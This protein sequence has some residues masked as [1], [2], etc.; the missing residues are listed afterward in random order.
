MIWS[1]KEKRRFPR[2]NA[3]IGVDILKIDNKKLPY[4]FD[5]EIGRNI[6]LGGICIELSKK[7]PVSTE[8]W[9][10]LLI[11]KNL[12]PIKAKGKVIWIKEY[13]RPAS[14]I[15]GIKVK[16]RKNFIMGVE[17]LEIAES[18]KKRINRFVTS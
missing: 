4:K 17:F 18:D 9:M 12:P 10:E 16:E 2:K 14:I 5:Q 1:G 3:L 8:L 13:I 15:G 6:G 7:L 11:D